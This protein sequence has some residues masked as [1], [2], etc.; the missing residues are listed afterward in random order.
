MNI[1]KSFEEFLKEPLSV[2]KK[3]KIQLVS[4]ITDNI[5]AHKPSCDL[6]LMKDGVQM[7]LVNNEKMYNLLSL[8]TRK[9]QAKEE[10]VH[11]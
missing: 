7:T 11:K 6:N 2:L 9:A 5:F 4:I 10:A 8:V 1:F 3:N